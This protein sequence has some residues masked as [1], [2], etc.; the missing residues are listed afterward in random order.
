MKIKTENND[1]F[2]CDAIEYI[3]KN[4]LPV[5]KNLATGFKIFIIT[6]NDP[7]NNIQ[8]FSLLNQ[9]LPNGEPQ[10]EIIEEEEEENELDIN[11]FFENLFINLNNETFFDDYIK[12]SI[13]LFKQIIDKDQNKLIDFQNILKNYN[14]N[15]EED[16]LNEL[17]K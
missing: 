5:E 15:I 9:N 2:Y 16:V 4:Y 14:I 7:Y 3:D 11:S 1:T 17:F 6:D 13:E 8:F 10:A 12:N